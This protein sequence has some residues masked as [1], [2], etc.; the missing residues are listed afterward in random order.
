MIWVGSVLKWCNPKIHGWILIYPVEKCMIWDHTAH[1]VQMFTDVWQFENSTRNMIPQI[2]R[3]GY[4]QAPTLAPMDTQ[5][6]REWSNVPFQY[7]QP[8]GVHLEE[9]F[10]DVQSPAYNVAFANQ[11]TTGHWEPQIDWSI[12]GLKMSET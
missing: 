2:D 12:L 9:P 5:I 1:H 10:G 11:Q 6:V 3:N 4:K 7:G 8:E